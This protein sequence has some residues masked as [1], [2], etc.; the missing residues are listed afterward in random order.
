MNRSRY[1]SARK[2]LLIFFI[3]AAILFA[4]TGNK[5]V[6]KISTRPQPVPVITA[7]APEPAPA[8]HAIADT[9]SQGE[10][11]F[12]I[13]MRHSLDPGELEAIRISTKS[14]YDI[15][16]LRLGN[17][18]K[19]E[20]DDK[21]S[22]MALTYSINDD[23][24]LFVTRT[25]DGFKA[26]KIHTEYEKKT[27][28]ISGVIRNNLVSSM[29]DLTLALKLSDIF[30]WDIDFNTDL[31]EGDSFRFVVE[32]LWHDGGFKKYGTILAAIFQ[33][34][35]HQYHAYRFLQ[36]SDAAYF[37]QN[38]KA[39]KRAFLKAPL[40]FR[41]ISSGY[42]N[43]RFHPI[44]K[45][46]K[47]HRGIDY[48]AARGTPVSSVGA[49]TVEFA[50]YKGPNGNL[51]I[52][53]HP[54]GYKTTY[55]HLHRIRKGIRK[56]AKVQQG[57]VIGSVGST[58]RSTGPHLDFRMKKNGRSINPLKVKLPKGK[59]VKSKY[60]ASFNSVR[61]TMALRLTTAIPYAQGG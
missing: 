14:T 17:A 39:L 57:Q 10:S 41:R 49:G 1:S 35:R 28:L 27:S 2:S 53:R 30:A 36:G 16:R 13:F 6:S 59:P 8:V 45:T 32:E 44:L 52:I 23:V 48:A 31:R 26:K 55:G 34:N 50:G 3:L 12:D 21:K 22:V 29:N 4:V 38:G 20:H 18:Y 40:S 42:T 24:T 61:D 19:I 43:R 15:N 7:P 60:M 46:Y 5:A 58:G 9:I 33:N 54:G 51:V 47:P 56:G 25:G 11:F 37:D